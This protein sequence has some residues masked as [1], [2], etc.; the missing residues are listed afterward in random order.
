MTAAA[1]SKI[2]LVSLLLI[3]LIDVDKVQI[4]AIESIIYIFHWVH[5]KSN[6]VTAQKLILVNLS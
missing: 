3:L 1:V 6:Y 5:R 2:R 4:R